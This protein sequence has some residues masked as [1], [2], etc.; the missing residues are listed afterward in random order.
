MHQ[1]VSRDSCFVPFDCILVPT[2]RGTSKR[3]LADSGQSR[4][5]ASQV[6]EANEQS[7]QR[8]QPSATRT[9]GVSLPS[10]STASHPVP[11]P[12]EEHTSDDDDDDDDDM[13]IAGLLPDEVQVGTTKKSRKRKRVEVGGETKKE[14]AVKEI[15]TAADSVISKVWC[16]SEDLRSSLC[17]H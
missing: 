6:A 10:S 2:C 8:L 1:S 15:L 9:C 17:E 12:A 7:Q 13:M 5:L 3:L 4:L 16:A 14:A 11:P